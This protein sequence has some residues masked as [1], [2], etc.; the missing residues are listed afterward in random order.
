MT[1]YRNDCALFV[2]GCLLCPKF[3]ASPTSDLHWRS[4]ILTLLVD[5]G[6]NIV[7]MP[8]PEASFGGFNVG[9]HRLPH[10]IK[11]YEGVPYF[12][13]H[14]GKL[15]AETLEKIESLENS[16]CRILAIVGIEHSPTCAV[17]YMY[18][19]KG[20]IKR[21]GIF[22]E[23]VYQMVRMKHSGITFIGINRRYPK[24][25]IEEINRILTLP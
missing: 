3:Q 11:Y 7:Q 21:K 25:A 13:E 10:G 8:C 5:S 23:Q 2:P 24:R 17:N 12:C 6:V 9:L 16:G 18:T 14:C 4:E 1:N 15:A 20:T 22:I 19:N